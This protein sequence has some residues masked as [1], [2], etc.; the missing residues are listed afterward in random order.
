[1]VNGKF[2]ST[3]LAFQLLSVPALS[4]ETIGTI[5]GQFDGE[6]LQWFVTTDDGKS[7]SDWTNM[8]PLADVNI[9]AQPTADTV[10]AIKGTLLIGFQLFNLNAT[11]AVATPEV[12]Y[13]KEGYSGMFGSRGDAKFTIEEASIQGDTLHVKGSFEGEIYYST[14]YL[15]TLDTRDPKMVS[16]QF[17]VNLDPVSK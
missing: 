12:T 4:Q 8:G 10:D 7:Q 14:D 1:M 6:E 3:A 17:D 16:G 5:T 11:P 2:I 9:F 15:R 13:L